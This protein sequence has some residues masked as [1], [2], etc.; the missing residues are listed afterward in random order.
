[1]K[2]EKIDR[3]WLAALQGCN[4]VQRRRL[5][6]V[7]ALQIGWG[8]VSYVCNL[9]K[10]SPNTIRKGIQE[11]KSGSL[12]K[13]KKLRKEGGGRKK[14]SDKNPQV[15]KALEKIMSDATAGD[16]MRLLKW[17][18]KSTYSIAEVLK[19]EGFLISEDTVGR[20]LKKE[21]YSLQANKKKYEGKSH[22]D[23]DEQFYYI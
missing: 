16:P 13:S 3:F 15:E 21:K 9:A 5:A 18:H 20:M 8:G 6:G 22:P 12:E 1:M 17:T 19:E 11:I 14:L 23:R 10:M 2:T 4:E 7:K